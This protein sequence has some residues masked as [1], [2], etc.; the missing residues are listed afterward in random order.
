MMSDEQRNPYAFPRHPE[1]PVS[2][3]RQRADGGMS[4]RDWFAGQALGVIVNRLCDSGA[5]PDTIAGHAAIAAYDV[6]DAMLAQR[7]R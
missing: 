4:L 3:E 1:H 2:D 6:A 7:E 5:K